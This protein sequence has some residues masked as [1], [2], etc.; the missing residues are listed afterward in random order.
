MTTPGGAYPATRKTN[1]PPVSHSGESSRNCGRLTFT[2][3]VTVWLSRFVGSLRTS[4]ALSLTRA[5]TQFVP[6]TNDCGDSVK[7][8]VVAPLRDTPLV[9][10]C[11]FRLCV[12][13][14]SRVKLKARACMVVTEKFVLA[15][16][17]PSTGRTDRKST[18]LN[19]S[20]LGI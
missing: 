9:N 12:A 13:G 1:R 3:Q 4:A 15:G 10:H 11:T 6:L 19:S 8:R 14:W 5:L 18:R 17:K 16:E 2:V 20:H 7:P